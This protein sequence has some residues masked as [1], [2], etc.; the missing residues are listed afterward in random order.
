MTNPK[1]IYLKADR[2]SQRHAGEI[3]TRC[4]NLIKT[5]PLINGNTNKPDLP[6]VR[7]KVIT[8][9]VDNRLFKSN[10][11]RRDDRPLRAEIQSH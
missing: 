3:Y 9:S 10:D 5:R 2:N 6:I 7:D 8:D 11:S 4:K 1:K